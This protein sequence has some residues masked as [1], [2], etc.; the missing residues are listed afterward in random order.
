MA[1]RIPFPRPAALRAHRQSLLLQPTPRSQSEF[2][3]TFTRPVAKVLLIAVL[4][5]QFVYWSWMKL[6]TDEIRAETDATIS[7]LEAKVEEYKKKAAAE[8]KGKDA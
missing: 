8:A 3:K 6:E 4:T 5:Y 2:Y 7:D 1:P